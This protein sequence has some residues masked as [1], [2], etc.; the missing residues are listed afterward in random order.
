MQSTPFDKRPAREVLEGSILR[1]LRNR[2]RESHRVA[3][4]LAPQLWPR[5][6][7][8]REGVLLSHAQLGVWVRACRTTF[9]GVEG[10]LALLDGCAGLQVDPAGANPRRARFDF[11]LLDEL[12]RLRRI[13]YPIGGRP[14]ARRKRA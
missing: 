5:C 10:G 4:L 7:E 1:T 9:E 14:R 3:G 12:A 6:L 11:G 2:V 13:G 8:N